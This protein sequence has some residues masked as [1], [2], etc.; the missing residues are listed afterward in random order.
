MIKSP[1][2]YRNL[3]RVPEWDPLLPFEYQE[4]DAQQFWT[5]E[6][7]KVKNG[8]TINGTHISGWLYWHINFWKMYVDVK[9]KGRIPI[10]SDLRD[11]EWFFA[12]NY[13]RALSERK[14]LAMFGTR[15]GGK[16]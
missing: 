13:S 12:E 7:R 11:N 4:K 6:A 10:L 15:R 8:I 1:E 5:E 2:L 9:G 14:G 16:A 3:K